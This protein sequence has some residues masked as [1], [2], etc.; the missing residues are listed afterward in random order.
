MNK[1][2]DNTIGIELEIIRHVLLEFAQVH[3]MAFERQ[4]LFVQHQPDLLRAGRRQAMIEFK[5][6]RRHPQP[7]RLCASASRL[8]SFS[9][10]PRQMEWTRAQSRACAATTC[11][12]CPGTTGMQ[13]E[14]R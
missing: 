10:R 8:W 6:G 9:M 5:T 13:M 2:R 4:L 1:R 7:R 3:Q 14:S 11:R 12:D